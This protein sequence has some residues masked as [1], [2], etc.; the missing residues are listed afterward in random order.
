[1]TQYVGCDHARTLLEGLVDGELSMTEQ[2]AVESHLRWCDTCALR[3]EDMRTIGAAM[4]AQPASRP[5]DVEDSTLTVMN[6]GLLIRVRAERAQSFPSRVRD[7]MSDRRLLWPALG[8]TSAVLLCVAAA[9]SVL[10]AS[11]TQS[12]E[13]LAG[14]I[15]EIGAPGTEK[16]PLRPADNGVSIPALNVDDSARAGGTLEQMPEDDLIYTIRTVMGRDGTISNYE[17]L[18]SDDTPAVNR[19][20]AARA[21]AQEV[22]MLN[23]VRNTRF[24]P[25]QTPLG[26]AVAVDM[27][28]VLAKTTAVIAP[29]PVR[30]SA[31][32][33]RP[34]EVAKPSPREPVG[35]PVSSQPEPLRH[36][37]TA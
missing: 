14:L 34:R 12:R 8:A 31:S 18:L 4:R 3:V 10:H 13:S 35:P 37:T 11:T 30:R 9:I 15:S 32:V 20:A 22:A 27:V 2:L 5:I 16:W 7:M 17:L 23:A 21:A 33:E 36:S 26:Q 6:Q 25:A 28:W 1:M 29:E 24:V 19:A